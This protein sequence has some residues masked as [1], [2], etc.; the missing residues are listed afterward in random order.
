MLLKCSNDLFSAPKANIEFVLVALS[1][2][3]VTLRPVLD[4]G[5]HSLLPPLLPCVALL[6]HDVRCDRWLFA[7]P[8]L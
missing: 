5:A 4:N 2:M 8:N 1:W 6:Q 7:N 3:A